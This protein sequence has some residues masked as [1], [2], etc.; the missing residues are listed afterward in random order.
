MKTI[1]F[2]VTLTIEEEQTIPSH[3]LEDALREA[4]V[5]EEN[6][7]QVSVTQIKQPDFK[8]AVRKVMGK[9]LSDC[10]MDY[11]DIYDLLRNVK[12]SRFELVENIEIGDDEF[13]PVWQP[14]EGITVDNFLN[15]V[16]S[17]LE[18]MNF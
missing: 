10:E 15:L 7:K 8:N 3:L 6:V 17:D 14:L 1:E 16:I 12:D 2:K 13:I 9:Y 4:F 11:Y 5:M 18:Q